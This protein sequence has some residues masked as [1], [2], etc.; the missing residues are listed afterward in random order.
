MDFFKINKEKNSLAILSSIYKQSDFGIA[1]YSLNGEAVEINP[2]FQKTLGCL[3]SEVQPQIFEKISLKEEFKKDKILYNKLL[4]KEINS[5]KFEKNFTCQ[6][7]TTLY[8]ELTISLIEFEEDAKLYIIA[9]IFD[10][11]KAKLTE[12]ELKKNQANYRAIFEESPTPIIEFDFSEVKRYINKIKKGGLKQL[13]DFLDSNPYEILKCVTKSKVLSINRAGLKL[14]KVPSLE[15]YQKHQHKFYTN[16]SFNGLKKAIINFS[17]K[18]NFSNSEHSIMSL[19]GKVHYVSRN[20]IMPESNILDWK[21]CFCTEIIISDRVRTEIELKENKSFVESVLNAVPSFIFIYDLF[22]E[23]VIFLNQS[24]ENILG[25]SPE[26]IIRL[27]KAVKSLIHKG[28]RGLLKFDQFLKNP[29]A[30]CEAVI[31]V[32]HKTGKWLWVLGKSFVFKENLAG[33][34]WRVIGSVFDITPRVKAEQKL[35][36]S[37]QKLKELNASKDLFFS[38]IT[39]D[40]KNPISVFLS[41]SNLLANTLQTMDE[42]EIKYFATELNSTA[43]QLNS[44]MND[45]LTWTRLQ[46]GDIEVFKSKEDLHS[47]CDFVLSL[48][49]KKAEEKGIKIICKIE[50][51]SFINAD[52]NMIS[53]IVKNLLINAIKFSYKDSEIIIEAKDLGDKYEISVKDFGVGIKKENIEKLFRIENKFTSLGTENEQGTGLGLILCKEF[54]EIHRGKIWVESKEG[55]GSTFFFTIPGH[56]E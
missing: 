44:M 26:E 55:S 47:I 51:Y 36:E 23:R 30:F 29:D 15:Q 45:L 41:I 1:V 17:N 13:S 43:R 3:D 54:V 16:E 12:I 2:A 4:N 8:S 35:I 10:I 56:K 7:G 52:L 27:G 37:E 42:N 48:L 38:I 53:S 18:Q 28:D 25:Y 6:D 19:N 11:S 14:Y 34:A 24:V 9:F 21:H 32:R 20:Y 49:R 50:K 5:Y 40:I 33:E 22:E 46:R 39:H 31:R